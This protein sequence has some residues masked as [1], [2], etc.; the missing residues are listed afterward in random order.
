[1]KRQKIAAA[2]A[3]PPT[4]TTV[5]AKPASAAKTKAATPATTIPAKPPAPPR[6]A[7]TAPATPAATKQPAKAK[8]AT[9][10]PKPVVPKPVVPQ[11]VVPKPAVAK[12]VVPKPVVPKP[13]VAK[14]VVPKPATAAAILGARPVTKPKLN[15][16]WAGQQK[17]LLALRERLTL[18]RREHSAEAA[19]PLERHGQSPADSATD[20]FDHDIALS[21]LSSDQDTLNEIDQAL[22]RIE[23]GTYG[24]CEATGKKIPAARLQAVP[25]TRFAASAELELEKKDAVSRAH[26]GQLGSLQGATTPN[27][28]GESVEEQM[29]AAD[30]KDEPATEAP[31]PAPDDL[32]AGATLRLYQP[33]ARAVFVA[34]SFND[35][36]PAATPLTRGAEGEWT[37]E[38][39]LAPGYYEYRFV[40]DDEWRDDPD[41][42]E[43][44][45][46]PYGGANAILRVTS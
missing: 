35:W 4:P 12:P 10:V 1:M 28:A 29:E 37:L 41:A 11:P 2:P 21:R 18:D 19:E 16:K 33:E 36:D 20:E 42:P 22:K 44:L 25:W 15:P 43:Y 5:P 7:K 13:A 6:A 24:I 26:V 30:A 38:L 9:V 3:L 31:V 45:P 23:Q 40:V 14:P 27:L 34:G 39:R 32:P 17:A 46:N 8:A